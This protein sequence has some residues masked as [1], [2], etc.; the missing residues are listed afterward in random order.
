[1]QLVIDEATGTIVDANT[2]AARFYG[3]SVEQL[4]QMKVAEINT[5]GESAV[6]GVF[7]KVQ[8]KE[9]FQFQ[10]QHRLADGS[11]REVEVFSNEM[12]IEGRTLLYSIIQDITD[13]KR[14]EA[15]AQRYSERLQIATRAAHIGIWDWDVVTNTQVWDDAIC[16]IYGVPPG[17]FNGGAEDWSEHL[18]PDDRNRVNEELQAAL[19]GECEYAPEFRVIRPDGSIRNIKANSQ[20]FWDEHGQ[21][22]RMVG[23]NLDITERKQMEQA[24]QNSMQRYRG[25]IEDQSEL[26]A[27]LKGDGTLVFANGAFCRFFGRREEEILGQKWQ[28]VAVA[29]D[30]AQIEA[31]LRQLSPAQPMVLIENRVCSGTGEIHWMEFINRAF[32]NSAGEL[33]EIQSVGRDITER[34][35]ADDKLRESE[36]KFRSVVTVVGE[37]MVLQDAAGKIT[38]HNPAAERILGLTANQI[39]GRESM[40]PRWRSVHPDGSPFPGTDHPAMVALRTGKAQQN[41]EMGVYK[42]NDELVWISINTEPIFDGTEPTPQAVVTSFQDITQRKQAEEEIRMVTHRLELATR[43]GGVG[44]WEY[45]LAD[46]R[47]IWDE[48][49]FR[50]Y[51]IAREQFGGAYAAWQAGVHPEDRQRGDDDIQAALRGEK[52]FDTEFRVL[53]PDGSTHYMR[54]MATV[55][56]DAAGQPVRMIGTNWDITERRRA[57][58]DIRRLVGELKLVL[59][60]APAGIAWLKD[61]QV[62]TANLTHDKMLG[63]APGGSV[64][65]STRA[66]YADPEEYERVGRD[67]YA[68]LARGETFHTEALLRRQDGSVFPC[69]LTGQAINPQNMDEGSIWQ[70]EDITERKRVEAA[71]SQSYAF[72]DSLL[73]A[74]PLGMEIVDQE[75]N[76]LFQNA[77]LAQAV[78]GK[79]TLGQKCWQVYCDNR[80]QCDKC[81]IKQPIKIGETMTM[82]RA[83]VLGGKTYEI[84]H[85]G[86]MYQGQPALLEVFHDITQRKLIEAEFRQAQKME[87]VGQLAGGVAHDLNNILAAQYFEIDLLPMTEPM[88]PGVRQGLAHVRASAERAAKLV[89]QLLL[90]SRRQRMELRDLDLNPVVDNFS[91]LLHRVLGEQIQLEINTRLEPL[92]VN[93]DAGMIEQVLMNLALNARDAMPNGGPLLIATTVVTF[94]VG[95]AL[96]H[97]EMPSGRYV[98]LSVADQGTG[99]PPEV[100]P[101]IF[102]PFFTTKD[103]GKG[104]GLG[105][106][107]VDGI[108]KQHQGWIDVENRPGAG[109]TFR[110]YFPA[111][112]TPALASPPNLNPAPSL[113]GTETILLVEDDGSVSKLI[114]Q[115]LKQKGY[116]VWVA[117][118][119]AEA[120]KIWAEQ[121]D[122]VA[123]LLT[124]IIMPDGMSGLEL[125]KQL[126]SKK[127]SLKVVYMSGYSTE[128]AAGKLDL[129]QDENFLQKPF[130]IDH[131]LKTLRNNLDK[132]ANA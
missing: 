120:L 97:R 84:T 74:L 13:R 17:S 83:E 126:L 69:S 62:V 71:L 128:F 114:S 31:Q 40:D 119:G 100:L 93:A 47:M 65:R 36:E 48:Q 34:K 26:V 91:K 21:P 1:M 25:L 54:A 30:V 95:D 66:F 56:R 59:D 57:E 32:F 127:P 80:E 129:R 109:V 107:S 14:A 90:F 77:A 39:S 60:T 7:H 105:L 6:Q 118:N 79:P 101:R 49:M 87:A 89:S 8:A 115:V 112:A 132:P 64:G 38:F 122:A 42:P 70:L 110:I 3:W 68:Q 19:R 116:V 61:R 76:I 11:I 53:W 10:F 103:V 94:A 75:G 12:E 29:E 24:L 18:H 20:T 41:V 78:G 117:A 85:T 104:S 92:W 131:L 63:F 88:S 98:C 45:E 52:D 86:M 2:A 125:A 33:L 102:E 15:E 72:N 121:W 9:Q 28:P 108:I 46:N 82:E 81:P 22:L 4:K 44:I 37:G 123:L 35:Q 27:R 58:D 111:L 130:I 16:E 96:P 124:D 106:A 43:A 5:Q 50:L 51:G 23:T 113:G 67:G 73:R 55:E 99:I